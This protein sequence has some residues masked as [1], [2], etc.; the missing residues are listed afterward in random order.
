[1][2]NVNNQHQQVLWYLINWDS[3]SLADVINDSMFHK[4]QSRA[5]EIEKEHG[6]IMT[7]S[8]KKFT[9]RFGKVR[10]Y[11][12]YECIDKNRAKELMIKY[13]KQ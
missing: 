2:K 3:F 1:M 12:I 6:A 8:R 11:L 5:A 10:S 4:Y 13:D 7:R 9:N